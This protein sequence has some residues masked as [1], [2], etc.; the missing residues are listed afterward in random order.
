MGV[1][2][3]IPHVIARSTNNNNV[4][5][6]LSAAQRT[7][8]EATTATTLAASEPKRAQPE[9]GGL[10]KGNSSHKPRLATIK[11]MIAMGPSTM[12]P[13]ATVHAPAAHA[14]VST[15]KSIVIAKQTKPVNRTNV[16]PMSP[17]FSSEARH[18]TVMEP[19]PAPVK[20]TSTAKLDTLKQHRMGR[21]GSPPMERHS[22]QN[23]A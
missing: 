16:S 6:A 2:T 20:N 22:N 1:S 11:T 13:I 17:L 15:V 10:A 7:Q 5:Q 4:T 19:L 9:N 8:V 21:I 23:V 18:A 12:S 14:N 3:K